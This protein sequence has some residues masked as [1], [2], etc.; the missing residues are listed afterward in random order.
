M[1]KTAL[2]ALAV[3]GL[4]MT[5]TVQPA[6]AHGSGGYHHHHKMAWA[7]LPIP[8]IRKTL[9]HRGYYRIRFIDRYLPVY[10]AKACKNGKRFKLRINRWGEIMRRK[11]VGWCHHRPYYY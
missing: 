2:A 5:A 4:A 7:G 1:F 11:R 10:K 6:A 9:R 3:M 8:K